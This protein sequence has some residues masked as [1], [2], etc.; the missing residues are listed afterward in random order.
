LARAFEELTV[1]CVWGNAIP[2]PPTPQTINTTATMNEEHFENP[3][4]GDIGVRG[5]GLKI[6]MVSPRLN[7]VENGECCR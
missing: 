7:V 1:S 3:W 5:L 6:S 4:C 2:V